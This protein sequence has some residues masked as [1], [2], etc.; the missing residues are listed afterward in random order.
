MNHVRIKSN[1]EP[2][3]TKI[4]IDGVELLNVTRLSF[5]I[6]TQ[7]HMLATVTATMY[8]DELDIDGGMHARRES[9]E[10]ARL[11]D[12]EALER[13]LMLVGET[14]ARELLDHAIRLIAERSQTA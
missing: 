1:G 13:A 8:V 6:G 14:G 7:E 4:W 11:T 5:T 9:R 12:L 3:E 2:H 10:V